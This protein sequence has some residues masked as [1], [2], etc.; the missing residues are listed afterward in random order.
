MTGPDTLDDP[1]L[2]TFADQLRGDVVRPDDER[3]DDA[4]TVWNAAVDREPALVAR[5]TGTADVVTAV[6][7]AREHDL[8]LAVRATGHNVAGTAVRD[9]GIVIDVR[10]IDGIRVDP[11][12]GTARV[13]PGVTWGAFD[14]E[15]G[16]F[17]LATPGAQAPGVGVVGTT[18]GGGI[19]WLSRG[20]GLTVDNVLSA[21]VVTA[22]G[23]LVRASPDENPDLFWGLRGGSGNFGV[24][25]SLELQLHEIGPR[26][27]AGSLLHPLEEAGAVLRRYRDW[28]ADAP[29]EVTTLASVLELPS[30]PHVPAERHGSRA[31]MIGV[32]YAGDLDRGERVLAPLRESGDPFVDTVRRRPYTEWQRAGESDAVLRTHQTSCYLGG[33]SDGAVDTFVERV[34]D[35]PPGAAAYF[36]AHD[37]A[38][39]DVSRDATAYPHRDASYLL[40]VEAR[41]EDPEQDDRYVTWVRECREAM[42]PHATGG[43]WVNALTEHGNRGHVSAA[44]GDNYD[45]L[46][47]VKTEWDPE[48]RFRTN[49][50]VEPGR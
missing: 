39:T 20:Y 1:I 42:R 15:T 26:V 32:C 36:L 17:G 7:V 24:V 19:G 18:L 33:L 45:R 21:D 12:T 9:G 28:M 41:W 30:A 8:P 35:A 31:V 47:D 48:N 49:H 38:V 22:E 50:N 4:R 2:A 25:T 44:Y 23:E 40:V 6:D 14:H 46:V 10:S 37:G 27:L 43:M 16:A 13:Q 34:T 5:C 11:E 29:D 3:Y